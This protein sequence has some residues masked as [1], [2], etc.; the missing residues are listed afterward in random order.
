LKESKQSILDVYRYFFRAYPVRSTLMVVLMIFSGLAEGVGLVTLFPV[1]E[2]AEGGTV[3][4][5]TAGR[6]VVEALSLL[7]LRPTL[8]TLLALIVLA[9]SL[10]AILLLVAQKQVGFTVARV[11][12]D[13]RLKLIKGLFEVRWGYF[14]TRTPGE[15]AASITAE[16]QRSG[17]AYNE[18][19]NIVS[20]LF[21]MM[22]YVIVATLVSVW[23]TVGVFGVAAVLFL[24]A[25]AYLRQSRESGDS[26]TRSQRTLSSRLVD[27]LQG[28]KPLKAMG[29]EGLV[30]PF[31]EHETMK[32]NLASRKQV[33]AAATVRA[34]Q[35]PILTLF[36]AIGLFIVVG[37]ASMPLASTLIMAFLF[38]RMAIHVNTLQMRYQIVLTLQSAFFSMMRQLDE[39]QAARETSTGT[40]VVTGLSEGIQLEDVS[41][42]YGE[43]PVLKGLN[44][45]IPAGSFVAVHGES[46]SGKTT[47]ADLIV[48]L[49]R[50]TQGLILVDGFPLGELDLGS[51]RRCIGYVP[52]EL[53]LFSESILLN[54]TLGD[55]AYSR[56]D[57]EMALRLAGAWDFVQAKSGGLDHPMGDRGTMVSGGQRQRIALARA[58]VGNP[59]LL[60]LDEVT[61]ALDPDTELAICNT[62]RSLTN[63]VTILAISHQEAMRNAASQVLMLRHGRMEAVDDGSRKA[64]A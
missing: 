62:L 6:A 55:P 28:V 46:G 30:W 37:M 39:I 29:R 51:W 63:R 38:Y 3:P 4:D 31:L 25:R 40:R 22:A 21:N 23:I 8:G 58:L 35:E 41:F 14:G 45:Y 48:G 50:P 47:F 19:C 7:N 43:G 54:V 24:V 16:S 10:K 57:A 15:F 12:L 32:L 9:I 18:S 44:A 1:L 64:L 5:N 56:E 36:L 59:S 13:L 20:A 33:R 42:D 49:H 52:Q 34:F 11:V 60:I 17:A 26:Q 27:V 61:T 53:L 2:I